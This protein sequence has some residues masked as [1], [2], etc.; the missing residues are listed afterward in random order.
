MK[1][2]SGVDEQRE[3]E[4]VCRATC[5]HLTASGSHKFNTKKRVCDTGRGSMINMKEE[6][7][8]NQ[9]KTVTAPQ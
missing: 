6:E 9:V 7:K 1:I 2:F 5:R 8:E 4:I 3:E